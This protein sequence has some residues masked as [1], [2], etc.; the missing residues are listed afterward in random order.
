MNMG[1]P[2]IIAIVTGVISIAI[3]I[4]YLLLITIFDFRIYLN[5]QL[6]NFT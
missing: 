1:R 4:A 5:E 2:K 6:S 3:C